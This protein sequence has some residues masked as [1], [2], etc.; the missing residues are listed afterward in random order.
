MKGF[1]LVMFLLLLAGCSSQTDVTIGDQPEDPDRPYPGAQT[2]DEEKQG[3]FLYRLVSSK[4]E[5]EVG[6]P[7]EIYAE[8][9]YEGDEED[10]TIGHANSPF[11]F[12]FYEHLRGYTVDYPM[13]EP[14]ITT[15]LERDQPLREDYSGASAPAD[16]DPDYQ[17]F[18][19]QFQE[20]EGLPIGEYTVTGRADFQLD[21]ETST[22]YEIV[23][24]VSFVVTE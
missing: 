13:P 21:E 8:L 16:D 20:N 1:F 5:Y 17:S 19:K 6:E 9:V 18:L 22:S 2:I 23:T 7:V 10:I 11:Y 4:E 12:L 24:E 3:E 14:Y 15:D